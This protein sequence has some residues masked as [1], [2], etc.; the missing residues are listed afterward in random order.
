[1]RSSLP[2]DIAQGV[3]IV[4]A[5]GV[6]HQLVEGFHWSMWVIMSPIIVALGALIGVVAHWKKNS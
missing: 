2:G 6:L 4:I 1:M 3:L 5:A